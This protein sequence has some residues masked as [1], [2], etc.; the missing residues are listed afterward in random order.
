LGGLIFGAGFALLGYCPGTV[1]AAAGTGALDALLGG[2]PGTIIGA[3]LFAQLYPELD[4]A[5]L[6]RGSFGQATLPELLKTNHW[7]IIVP[8]CVIIVA[9]YGCWKGRACERLYRL[10]GRLVDLQEFERA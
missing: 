1:V 8:V 10:H 3:A 9:C 7:L 4:R 6:Q 5:I 2:I